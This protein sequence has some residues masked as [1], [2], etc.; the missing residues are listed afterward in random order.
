MPCLIHDINKCFEQRYGDLLDEA[1]RCY[2]YSQRKYWRWQGVI[3]HLRSLAKRSLRS[4]RSND[5]KAALLCQGNLQSILPNAYISGYFL[6]ANKGRLSSSYKTCSY[7]FP[8]HLTPPLKLW[9]NVFELSS[10]DNDKDVWKPV[11]N[12]SSVVKIFNKTYDNVHFQWR[13]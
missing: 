7:I 12:S 2:Q 6:S 1:Q 11:G 5:E 9:Q 10:G 8:I 4:W 13:I 3:T